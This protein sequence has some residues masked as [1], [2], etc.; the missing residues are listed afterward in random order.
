M[1][2]SKNTK[3]SELIRHNE[4]AIEVIASINPHF[5]KL[6][7]PLLRKVLAPRVTIQ[8]AAKIGN[9][10][11]EIFLSKLREIGFETDSD[12]SNKEIFEQVS[13]NTNL[14]SFTANREIFT[15]DV[16]PILE[17]GK[18]PFGEIMEA[19]AKLDSLNALKIVNTFKP[20]PLIKILEKK[21]YNTLVENEGELVLT[22][23]LK[24]ENSQK[25]EKPD[26]SELIFY[27]NSDEIE[28]LRESFGEKITEADVREMEMPLPMMTILGETEKLKDDRALFVHHKKIP[29]YL[30]PE[31]AERKFK[32]FIATVSEG[33]VKL[34]IHK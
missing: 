23:V 15:L 9:S 34:L 26:T 25:S 29:Q 10:T 16:R 18:D 17:S 5:N 13:P 30:L 19:I 2:I 14:K 21:G 4:A 3:I 1:K 27:V 7:N 24:P 31:L 11:T 28:K 33:N 32:T 20:V 6:K 12:E 22:Y 8:E